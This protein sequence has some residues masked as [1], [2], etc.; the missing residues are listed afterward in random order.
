MSI[1]KKHLRNILDVDFFRDSLDLSQSAAKTGA[2]VIVFCGVYF[3]AET[4]YI[5]SPDKTV[6]LPDANAGCPMANMITAEKLR[7]RK[8]ELPGATVVCYLNST[9]EVKAES[10]ICC[11]SSN[12]TKVI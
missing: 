2:E 10:D 11:T 4:A 3:M 7:D 5:L 1:M 9:A 12:T 6:L 8:K